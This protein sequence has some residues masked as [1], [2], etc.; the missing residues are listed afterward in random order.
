MSIPK[1]DL[2]YLTDKQRKSLKDKKMPE[3]Q[4]L[5]WIADQKKAEDTL[6]NEA[7]KIIKALKNTEEQFIEYLQ[8]DI[9]ESLEAAFT[10]AM[11]D[12]KQIDY[13]KGRK[14]FL[15][16][17]T[18]YGYNDS[19]HEIL[20]SRFTG[21]S[22]TDSFTGYNKESY[23]DVFFDYVFNDDEV[24]VEHLRDISYL[25]DGETIPED[26]LDIVADDYVY[27]LKD[28]IFE[29]VS[30]KI[31]DIGMDAF[32]EENCLYVASHTPL[33]HINE[34]DRVY[35][36]IKEIFDDIK[37]ITGDKTLTFTSI[38]QSDVFK[39]NRDIQEDDQELENLESSL[40]YVIGNYDSAAIIIREY[41]IESTNSSNIKNIYGMLISDGKY[42]WLN[43]EEVFEAMNTDNKTGELL[44]PD[45][46][47][48]Y[49][50][51]YFKK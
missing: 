9:Q 12:G 32:I 48:N 28:K 42:R 23:F 8:E 43:E 27:E 34:S 13:M 26:I 45:T 29:E 35:G 6:K 21:E 49:C 14:A 38:S 2:K 46:S 50:G 10:E 15:T 51:F 41:P 33:S 47:L 36:K 11:E 40:Y 24:I 39:L 4:A 31:M 17:C 25:K 18:S 1:E 3:S 7:D 20:F 16:D 22:S 37:M 19:V 44:E 30:E 5:Q